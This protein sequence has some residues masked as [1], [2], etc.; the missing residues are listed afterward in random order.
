MTYLG[1]VSGKAAECQFC[2][3]TGWTGWEKP[4]TGLDG[5]ITMVFVPQVCLCKAG[6]NF[7]N[8]QQT[9]IRSTVG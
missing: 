3:D 5:K 6:N 9:V 1:S 8:L 4:I 7:R 2:C